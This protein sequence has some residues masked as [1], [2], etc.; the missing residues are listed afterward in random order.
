MVTL[1]LTSC[2]L[3][4]G[5]MNLLSLKRSV[6]LNQVGR[7]T[8]IRFRTLAR[9]L[10]C[11]SCGI[12][13]QNIDSDKKGYYIEPNR[14][15]DSQPSLQDIK[16]LLFSQDIQQL[17]Q[18]DDIVKKNETV[19]KSK[20]L[21][22]KRCSDLLYQNRYN[23]N[24]FPRISL[25]NLISRI[26]RHSNLIVLAPLTEF[27]LHINRKLLTNYNSTLIFTKCDQI[28]PSAHTLEKELP[29]FFNQFFKWQFKKVVLMVAISSTKRW[30]IAKLF[31]TLKKKTY[32]VGV[33]NAG[34]S[35]LINTLLKKY[36]GTKLVMNQQGLI[37]EP[38]QNEA[39]LLSQTSGVSYVPNMTRNI[40]P[41]NINGKI[42]N[43]LPGY[44]EDIDE[45]YL[46]DIIKRNW[47]KTIRKTELFKA[48]KIKRK[49]YSSYQ[50]K[51]DSKCYTIGGIINVIAPRDSITQIIKYVAGESTF[52]K[53]V[54]RMIET[55]DNCNKNDAHPLSKYCG[56]NSD[57]CNKDKFIRHIL[58]PFQGSID[59]VI[60]GIGYVTLRST[61]KYKYTGLYEVWLPKGLKVCIREPLEKIIMLT[62]YQNENKVLSTER[63]IISSTYPMSFDE[64]DPLNKMKEMYLK[65][66]EHDLSRRKFEKENP[67]DI[68]TALHKQ[69]PNLYWY[70]KW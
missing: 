22:C 10:N 61:G 54:D 23:I 70:Y 25:N 38:S 45:V 20:P 64:K 67:M 44:T 50:T 55:F 1:Q 39:K 14:N 34:K 16:Y 65:R 57:Y 40:Q 52:F 68:V 4:T 19:K 11:N 36:H 9:L 49:T 60:Q 26:P 63:E 21:I 35:T 18:S 66:T 30:G 15:I 17:N 33:A 42:V 53:N 7:F 2:C 48:S 62:Y 5:G 6:L 56:L 12:H 69:S 13:L 29:M 3:L 46:E 32:L 31:S 24:E 37:S 41:F 51:E 59:V 43:D 8:S 47:L 28:I 58:P 27:P